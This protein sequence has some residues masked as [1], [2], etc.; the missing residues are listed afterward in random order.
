MSTMQA[1]VEAEAALAAAKKAA[2]KDE[3]QRN[4]NQFRETR[5]QIKTL[6]T[7]FRELEHSITQ[8]DE[9]RAGAQ[10]KV[11]GILEEMA[12]HQTE[13]PEFADILGDDDDDVREWNRTYSRLQARL[14]GAIDSRDALPHSE[15]LRLELVRLGQRIAQLRHSEHNLANRVRGTK[16]GWQGGVGSVR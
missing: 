7:E 13:R 12:L 5:K 2:A 1:V 6:E 10:S 3:R 16:N 15:P 11:A 14:Q 9:R 4:L 8:A